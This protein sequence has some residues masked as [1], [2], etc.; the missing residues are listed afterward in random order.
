M[1]AEEQLEMELRAME[2]SLKQ[3][4][5]QT[6]NKCEAEREKRRREEKRMEDRRKQT[7]TDFQEELRRIMETK[8][9]SH[10]PTICLSLQSVANETSWTS[11]FWS[12]GP[13]Y[14]D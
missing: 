12:F 9:V 1:E 6:S 13:I 2:I 8:E 14:D 5:R 3:K 10:C 4:E 7:E 11:L